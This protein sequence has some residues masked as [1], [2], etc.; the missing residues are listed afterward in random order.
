MTL[1]YEVQTNV[2]LIGTKS[3]T[4]RTAIEMENTYQSESTTEDTKTFDCGGF[5]RVEFDFLY[6]M[7]SSETAN[8]IQVIIIIRN[9]SVL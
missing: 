3:G 4:T 5:P 2:V 1:D 6:T 8:S 7:G 9:I